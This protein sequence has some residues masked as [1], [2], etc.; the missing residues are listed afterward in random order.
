MA[1]QYTLCMI[2]PSAVMAGHAPDIQ[3]RLLTEGFSILR[4]DEKTISADDARAFYAEHQAR[5]N[6]E[7][8]LIPSITEGPTVIMLLSR[9][10]AIPYLRKLLKEPDDVS[11]RSWRDDYG[12]DFVAN[13]LHASDSPVS[14]AREILFYFPDMGCDDTAPTAR[15]P[16]Y[17]PYVVEVG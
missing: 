8:H 11:G 9:D 10:N 2:K 7:T 1:V 5:E 13:G 6:F 4:T 17:I 3:A 12:R 15:D 16:L 14:A